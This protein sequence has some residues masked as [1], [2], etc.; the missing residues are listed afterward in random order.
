MPNFFAGLLWI[1][2][3]F[4][5]GLIAAHLV[6][7][8]RD[9]VDRK[10]IKNFF[11]QEKMSLELGLKEK[12]NA[13][14]K[15]INEEVDQVKAAA[16]QKIQTTQAQLEQ[17]LEEAKKEYSNK[18]ATLK[19]NYD[20]HTEWL[21]KDYEQRKQQYQEMQQKELANSNKANS[22]KIAAAQNELN[23]KLN[24]LQSDYETAAEKAKLDF[25]A[26]SEQIDLRK[27][28]LQK[29]I[30]SY[31]ERQKNV[32]ARFQEDEKIKSERDFFHISISENAKI[33]VN[34]LKNLAQTF[35]QPN[36]IYK[37]IYEVYYKALTEALFKKILGENIEKGGIYKITDLTNEKVY[38]GRAVNF[39]ERWRTHCKRGCGIEKINGLL[40]DRMMEIGLENFTFE[41]V[42]VCPKEQQ[43]EKEKYWIKFYHSDEWGYNQNKGG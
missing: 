14:L 37:L 34:K 25:L 24:K 15:E 3:G 42:E 28:T 27:A 16:V 23:D 11:N 30:E 35:N 7:F 9:L 39:K 38:I 20:Y 32:I 6:S 1:F 17:E 33:D 13:Q 18:K 10:N 2:V 5:L 8:C 4:C 40:Y 43:S 26:F 22:E 36:I 12:K 21:K 29:E 31:E 41:V 19:S